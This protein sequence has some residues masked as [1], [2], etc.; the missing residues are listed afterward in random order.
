MMFIVLFHSGMNPEGN[1]CC[2]LLENIIPHFILTFKKN[3]ALQTLY[4]YDEYVHF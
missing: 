3:Q 2:I 4:F 1:L